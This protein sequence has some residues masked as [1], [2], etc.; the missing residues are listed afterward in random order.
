MESDVERVKKIIHGNPL[1]SS[2]IPGALAFSEQFEKIMSYLDIGKQEGANVLIGGDT[3]RLD[4]ELS[5]GFYV[6]LTVF[7]GNNHGGF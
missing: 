4:G 1:E 7:A 2:I 3:L 6:Q 5:G